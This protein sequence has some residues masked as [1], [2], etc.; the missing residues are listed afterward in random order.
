MAMK[1]GACAPMKSMPMKSKPMPYKHG[2][3]VKKKGGKGC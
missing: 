1:K 2:G 3:A